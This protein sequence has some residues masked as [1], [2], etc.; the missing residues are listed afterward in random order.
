MLYNAENSPVTNNNKTNS[1]K[2]EEKVLITAESFCVIPDILAKDQLPS[3]NGLRALSILIVL[4]S[5][6]I[7]SE[8]GLF[9]VQI[10]FVISGFLITTLLIKEKISTGDI[11]LKKFYIRRSLRI[12]PVALLFLVIAF[13]LNVFFKL[14]IPSYHFILA[15]LFMTDFI[16]GVSLIGHYWSLSV[17][18]QFYLIFPYFIKKSIKGYTSFLLLFLI[19]I[20]ILNWLNLSPYQYSRHSFLHYFMYVL[21]PLR[22]FDAIIIGSLAS[23]L[24]FHKNYDLQ[25]IVKYKYLFYFSLAPLAVYLFR[26]NVSKDIYLMKYPFNSSIVVMILAFLIVI[27]LKESKDIIFN[28]LNNK[29]MSKLG[30]LSYSIYIW[31]QIFTREIPWRNS[32]KYGGSTSL[33]LVALALISL[34]SYYLYER[35]FIRI[36]DKFRSIS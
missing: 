11:N 1:I 34:C 7:G 31:Q 23:I 6:A 29:W 10:F 35:K 26:M 30:V 17:E 33:N 19:G 2:G 5:H 16:G 36:K 8:F 18:E 22:R 32:V 12:L 3:L 20:N 24:I 27:N 28:V 21:I 9:G 15:G 4:Y 25:T 13:G 14:H